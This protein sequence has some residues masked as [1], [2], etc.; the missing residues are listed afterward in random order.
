M[1]ALMKTRTR[2]AFA[3]L[4]ILA[5]TTFGSVG[6]SHQPSQA[7]LNK[8]YATKGL[9]ADQIS[10]KILALQP[11]P[12]QLYVTIVMWVG[13]IGAV[14]FVSG[15]LVKQAMDADKRGEIYVPGS[16]NKNVNARR[17]APKPKQDTNAKAK[18]P[19]GPI[20]KSP[21]GPITKSPT[22][23]ITRSPTGPITGSPTGPI[24]RSP[25]GPITGSPTGPITRSP[26]G[27][28]TGSPTGPI[29]RTPTGPITKSPT[30]PITRSPTGPI[31]PPASYMERLLEP[32]EEQDRL[33]ENQAEVD[34]IEPAQRSMSF[35]TSR[36][37]PREALHAIVIRVGGQHVKVWA[38]E[39]ESARCQAGNVPL[40][41]AFTIKG[42][43]VPWYQ[44][45]KY[46]PYKHYWAMDDRGWGGTKDV[47]S[48]WL[49]V[50]SCDSELKGYSD[51]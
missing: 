12:T 17:P 23:P 31:G 16:S 33:P 26:T 41:R 30:G 21:T 14:V 1:D 3:A 7:E 2:L 43:T 39:Q 18:S 38:T 25:T 46:D 29:T 47:I 8:I 34:A 15:Y 10:D 27:P 4:L 44:W 24:T 20:T 19:T 5:V 35:F 51:R 6:C 32:E 11:D 48:C 22:G 45:A 28:I 50:D 36:P 13:G 9:S 49:K 40:V 42:K 37:L